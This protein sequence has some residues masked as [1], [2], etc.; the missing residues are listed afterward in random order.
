[1]ADVSTIAC[2][3][4]PPETI[5]GAPA[6]ILRQVDGQSYGMEVLARRQVGRVT[7]WLAYTWSRSERIYS[8]GL[9]P[10]DFDQ[11]HV[12]NLVVQAILPWRLMVSGRIYFATGRPYT[13]VTLDDLLARNWPPRNNARLPDYFQ[14]DLRID[15]E[16]IFN[17]WALDVFVEVNNLTYSQIVFG[18]YYPM[19]NGVTRYDMPTVSGYNV[20]LPSIGVRGRF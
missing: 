9:R 16:W 8:C 3:S 13:D 1:V 18:V 6:A 11:T 15:R 12:L 5:T 4:P 2:V 17:K 7:G 14:L 20:I 19:I 10:S